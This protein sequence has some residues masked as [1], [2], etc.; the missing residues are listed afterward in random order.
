MP[1]T[2]FSASATRKA[3]RATWQLAGLCALL[4]GLSSALGGASL[5]ADDAES[6]PAAGSRVVFRPPFPPKNA[7]PPAARQPVVAAQF[8]APVVVNDQPAKVSVRRPAYQDSDGVPFDDDIKPLSAARTYG[9]APTGSLP[10]DYAKQRF[11]GDQEVAGCDLE[12]YRDVSM[13]YTWQATGLSF[14]SLYFEDVNL[15]RYGYSHGILQPAA[16][17]I[18]FFGTI[19]L[20]PY[21]FGLHPPCEEIYTLGY[22]RPGNPVPY[23]TSRLGFRLRAALLE[24]G[25]VVGFIYMIP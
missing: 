7:T 20:L 3:N 24:A 16:S 15:E 6:S 22:Y 9:Q 2:L 14:Q 11:G 21:K 5:A 18:H 23:R 8:A 25:A 19:P 10:T 13:V 4:L 12:D 17:A 1:T